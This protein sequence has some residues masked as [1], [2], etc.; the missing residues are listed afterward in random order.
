MDQESVQVTLEVPF[1]GSGRS[2]QAGP[3]GISTQML[4]SQLTGL[5]R[6]PRRRRGERR[7]RGGSW[8]SPKVTQKDGLVGPGMGRLAGEVR[9]EPWGVHGLE[10][11]GS[12]PLLLCCPWPGSEVTR[13]LKGSQ[14]HGRTPRRTEVL[15]KVVTSR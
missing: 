9:P 7:T 8:D 10:V 2:L 1:Q 5:M 3:G 15:R 14:Q 13:S 6:S 4:K 11:P 12:H